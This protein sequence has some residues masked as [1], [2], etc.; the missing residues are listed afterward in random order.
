MPVES[1]VEVDPIEQERFRAV[2]KA[3]SHQRVD[4][5]GIAQQQSPEATHQLSL[6]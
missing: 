3:R 6:K 1:S 4:I 2:D 5:R